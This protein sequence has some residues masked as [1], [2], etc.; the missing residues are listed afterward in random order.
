M[1]PSFFCPLPTIKA[2]QLDEL[3]TIHGVDRAVVVDLASTSESPES[4][5]DGYGGSYLS[6]F[7]TC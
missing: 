6:F 4:V 7:K 5:C 3:Y 1:A 2:D